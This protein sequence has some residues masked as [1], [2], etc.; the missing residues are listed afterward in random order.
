MWC[1]VV[2]AIVWRGRRHLCAHTL[3][4]GGGAR[5]HLPTDKLGTPKP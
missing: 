5:G 2:V 4:V 3:G 1:V